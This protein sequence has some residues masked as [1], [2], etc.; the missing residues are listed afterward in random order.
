MDRIAHWIARK[1]IESNAFKSMVLQAVDSI[2][3]ANIGDDIHRNLEDEYDM[4]GYGEDYGVEDNEY[5]HE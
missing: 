2:A 3:L 1:T 5:Y 4:Q